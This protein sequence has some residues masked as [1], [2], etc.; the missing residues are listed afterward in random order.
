MCL[1]GAYTTANLQRHHVLVLRLY[2]SNTYR[3][4]NGPLRDITGAN[5]PPHPFRFIAYVTAC[6]TVCVTVYVTACDCVCDCV[7]DCACDYACC[8]MC[9]RCLAQRRVTEVS[10]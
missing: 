5:D 4:L 1:V 6:A 8:C 9:T 7:C 3:R 2:T 10:V